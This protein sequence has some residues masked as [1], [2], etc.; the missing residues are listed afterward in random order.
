MLYLNVHSFLSLHPGI[1]PKI[2]KTIIRITWLKDN[3]Q[4][5]PP[6]LLF[7]CFVWEQGNSL[8]S[9]EITLVSFGYIQ[10]NN[11]IS[12]TGYICQLNSNTFLDFFLSK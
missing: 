5:T 1:A 4:L 7:P 9:R 11:P 10:I 8:Y 2:Q 3:H 12:E 6:V